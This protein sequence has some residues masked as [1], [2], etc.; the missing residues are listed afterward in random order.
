MNYT[1]KDRGYFETLKRITEELS[2]H[3]I[4]YAL[5]GG[6]AVQTRVADVLSR[7]NKLSIPDIPEL[8]TLLRKTKDFDITTK[9]LEENFSF[10]SFFNEFQALNP[11]LS[12]IEEGPKTKRINLSGKNP[13]SVIL[14]Y[15]AGPQDLYGLD[16]S[17]YFECIDTAEELDLR[18]NNSR[19]KVRVAKPE[20]I[21]TSKLTRADS[22]DIWDISVLLKT[23]EQ[24][25][26]YTP[27]FKPSLVKFLLERAGRGE[28]YGRLEEIQKQILKK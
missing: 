7:A 20:Y 9:P 16:S 6:A 25:R 21:I 5:V 12:I 14:N 8:E 23:I 13:V 24:H 3:N 18:Y 28:I 10:V 26:N 1:L 15:Q 2:R 11:D 27:K 4:S 19:S 22:K 17:F